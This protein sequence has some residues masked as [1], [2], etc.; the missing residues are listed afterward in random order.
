MKR[1][2]LLFV[3]A[4]A[5]RAEFSDDQF[6]QQPDILARLIASAQASGGS[7]ASSASENTAYYLRRAEY[8]GSCEAPFGR[9]HAVEFFFTRSTAKGSKSPVRGHTFVLFFDVSLK[10]RT[11]W[12]L[13][14]PLPGLAFEHTKLLLG[15]DTLFDFARPPASGAVIVGGKPQEV[16]RWTPIK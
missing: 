6:P 7:L 2:L 15:E 3:L 14:M 5:A 1:A 10:L 11:R 12:D 4:S 16:P 9:V 8:I 13:D